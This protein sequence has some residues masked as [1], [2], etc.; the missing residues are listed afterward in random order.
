MV[1]GHRFE[2]PHCTRS[3][4]PPTANAPLQANPGRREP[5]ALTSADAHVVRERHRL[6]C[7]CFVLA[8]RCAA[9]GHEPFDGTADEHLHD[10][11]RAGLTQRAAARAPAPAAG[12]GTAVATTSAST[13]S[14]ATARAA[15]ASHVAVD[16]PA[17]PICR[18]RQV[19]SRLRRARHIA[20]AAAKAS[21]GKPPPAV[22]AESKAAEKERKKQEKG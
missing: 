9:A 12:A 4:P 22:P 14:S 7:G 5:G 10:N 1:G 13:A 19:T 20:A 11:A 8:N 17:P 2:R 15:S 16:W 3:E 6:F 21:G 18:A